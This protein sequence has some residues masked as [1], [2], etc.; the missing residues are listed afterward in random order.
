MA[1]TVAMVVARC[2]KAIEDPN[3]PNGRMTSSA[4]WKNMA[5]ATTGR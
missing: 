3:L 5:A 4:G 1:A 2:T